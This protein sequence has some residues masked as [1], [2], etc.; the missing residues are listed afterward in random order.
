LAKANISQE[1]ELQTELASLTPS[2]V[3]AERVSCTLQEQKAHPGASKGQ[4][5]DSKGNQ[6]TTRGGKR[7]NHAFWY[8]PA[9]VALPPLTESHHL[10]S[11][12]CSA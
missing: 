6:G 7:G 5:R 9:P 10:V 11:E 12:V 8:D 2:T 1:R 3:L 4:R